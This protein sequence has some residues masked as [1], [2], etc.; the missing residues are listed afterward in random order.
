[1]NELFKKYIGQYDWNLSQSRTLLAVS[2][3]ID[4]ITMAELFFKAGYTFAIAHCNFQLRGEDSDGD[5][6]FVQALAEK[7]NAPFY[8]I[9]FE[10][11]MEA[12]KI[13]KSVQE[14]ARDLRYNWLEKVRKNNGYDY[15]ATAH[16]LNDSVE[17]LLFNLSR[18]TGLRGLTGIP[19]Q[20][21]F[22][23]RPMMGVSRTLI[24]RYVS[25]NKLNYREDISNQSDKYS[26][27][28]IRHQIIPLF[29]MLNPDFIHSTQKTLSF[30]NAS[31]ELLLA[32]SERLHAK[33]IESA[34]DQTKIDYKSLLK[35][36]GHLFFLHNYLQA[37]GFNSY[38]IQHLSENT[39]SSGAQLFS[40]THRLLVDRDQWII[41]PKV[42]NEIEES[43]LIEENR[44]NEVILANE[45]ITFELLEGEVKIPTDSN[46]A[47]LD[48]EKLHF[49][50]KLRKW[51]PGDRF[52]PLGMAGKEQKVK[53]FFINN[54]FSIFQK[55]NTWL[56]LSQGNI[57][58]IVAH[59]ISEHFKATPNTTKYL[60]IE[61]K[62]I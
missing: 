5:Q 41:M 2:G 31:M 35:Q 11:T 29:E 46:K 10:T 6:D 36:P 17:T 51:K 37:F 49:P 42:N 48:Y 28:F 7:Y 25:K 45:Q 60:L 59:R 58:W 20:Q 38:Q 19:V 47:L 62:K 13:K 9:R 23:I 24:E 52:A 61:W 21:G 3:G 1:M 34:R 4:S 56:L 44:T 12:Q 8:S 26:R 33:F 43:I 18:G 30:L 32:E 57:C 15:I 55:E 22:V 54:K 16:H 14:T 40:P 39:M 53:D 50:L 27:N